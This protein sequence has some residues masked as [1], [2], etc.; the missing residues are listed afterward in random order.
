MESTTASAEVSALNGIE[1]TAQHLGRS[2]PWTI[3]KH[4]E[5]GNIKVVRIGRRVFIPGDEI[6]R[7][8]RDGLPPLSAIGSRSVEGLHAPTREER[9]GRGR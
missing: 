4:I 3:R 9:N 5:R 8:Q 7:I 6:R 1:V 2:S